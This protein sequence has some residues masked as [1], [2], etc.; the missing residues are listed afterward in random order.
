MAQRRRA[1]RFGAA[2]GWRCR[3]KGGAL[4]RKGAKA[5]ELRRGSPAPGKARRTGEPARRMFR[6]SADLGMS[7]PSEGRARGVPGRDTPR[8]SSC[9][10]SC[11]RRRQ[12]AAFRGIFGLGEHDAAPFFLS[13]AERLCDRTSASVKGRRFAAREGGGGKSGNSASPE[14][15]RL[16]RRGCGAGPGRSAGRSRR[17]G[18]KKSEPR[19]ECAAT[20]ER[21]VFLPD[22]ALPESRARQRASRF[23]RRTSCRRAFP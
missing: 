12:R 1:W 18:G 7:M 22:A 2:G 20:G 19:R 11:C 15:P 21:G 5:G 17:A 4:R 10:P 13:A 16:W 23:P 9:L 14:A 6:Q 8:G 3:G